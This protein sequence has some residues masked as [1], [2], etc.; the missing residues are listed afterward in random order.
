[1]GRLVRLRET[2]SRKT[3]PTYRNAMLDEERA[4]KV[5]KF[6]KLGLFARERDDWIPPAAIIPLGVREAPAQILNEPVRLRED[7]LGG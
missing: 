5:S 7:R 3:L 1:M 4:Q 2:R 6:P